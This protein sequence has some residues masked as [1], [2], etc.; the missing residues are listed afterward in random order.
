MSSRLNDS[1]PDLS[2][3]SESNRFSHARFGDPGGF[4]LIGL[5]VALM[6]G[7][8]GV[9]FVVTT[10]AFLDAT[11]TKEEQTQRQLGKLVEVIAGVP[12]AN[13]TITQ[14]TGGFLGDTGRLPKSLEELNEISPSSQTLCDGGFNPAAAPTFHSVDAGPTNHRGKVGMGWSGPYYKEMIYTDEHLRDAWGVKFRYTC[15]ET[16]R[17]EDGVSLTVRTGQITSAGKDGLFDTVDDIKADPIHD[18]G[19]L[20]LT[21][22]QGGADKT[23]NPNAVTATL[24]YASNGE[25]VSVASTITDI[26]TDE[27]SESVAVFASVPAGVR[28]LQIDFGQ[29]KKEFYHTFLKSNVANDINIKIPLGQGG[30]G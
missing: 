22:T 12:E 23:A 20:F 8:F 1:P 13:P 18:R 25:Q 6:A 28:F 27:G 2:G 7:L 21:I 4:A 19:H 3:R 30:K 15:P 16:T 14:G 10:V 17:V 29:T 5:V 9:V 26:N 11:V 24:Y